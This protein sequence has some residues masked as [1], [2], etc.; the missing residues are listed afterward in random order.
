MF[1]KGVFAGGLWLHGH[2]E[3]FFGIIVVLNVHIDRDALPRD[4]AVGFSDVNVIILVTRELFL[5][6]VVVLTGHAQA[7]A[8][9]DAAYFVRRFRS[10]RFGPVHAGARLVAGI[11]SID[12]SSAVLVA[13]VNAVPGLGL[14]LLALFLHLACQQR[15]LSALS[16]TPKPALGSRHDA[17]ET[18][19]VQSVEVAAIA[20]SRP[21][22]PAIRPRVVLLCQQLAHALV[23]VKG[24]GTGTGTGT[25]LPVI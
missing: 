17:A 6:G 16:L 2:L 23:R 8:H 25:V 14:E 12:S 10:R 3:H 21:R 5:V 19:E 7:Q 15:L 11:D 20:G 24:T 13:V 1:A 9:A 22:R 4:G 18:R